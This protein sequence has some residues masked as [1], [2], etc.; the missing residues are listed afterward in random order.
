MGSCE[1]ASQ[2]GCDEA[3]LN[4]YI[5]QYRYNTYTIQNDLNLDIENRSMATWA[6]N[7]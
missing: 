6:Y 4:M 3:R 5:Y 2:N 7:I 1:F